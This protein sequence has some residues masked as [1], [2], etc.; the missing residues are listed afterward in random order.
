MR[1]RKSAYYGL[2]ILILACA[3]LELTAFAVVSYLRG[4]GV[5]YAPPHCDG[6]GRYLN[7]RD[8]VLGWPALDSIS[9][10]HKDAAGARITRL[11][12]WRVLYLGI[13]GG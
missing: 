2:V 8:P 9:E 11:A 3:L 7:R 4:K 5:Y 1:R 13:G 10:L 6:Y 12:L